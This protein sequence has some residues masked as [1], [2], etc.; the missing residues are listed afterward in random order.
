MS[1][2]IPQLGVRG[3]YALL[4]P[5]NTLLLPNI[6]YTCVAIRRLS[7]IIAVGGDPFVDYYEPFGLDDAA[8]KADVEAGIAIVSLQADASNI[9]RVPSSYISGFPNIGGVPYTTLALAINLGAVPDSL[10][11]SAIK[12]KIAAVV[13]ESV[14]IVS[15]VNT[16]A[17][18][19]PTLLNPTDAAVVE[20]ARLARITTVQTDYAKL[21]QIQALLDDARQQITELEEFIRSNPN[22][23]PSVP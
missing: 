23:S 11:L 2:F 10:N 5:Y 4:P 8:Y 19:L 3:L 18:S 20:A 6:G 15:V 7:D 22:I 21:L 17:V 13:L 9:A 16:V 12:N 14:G 1:Q